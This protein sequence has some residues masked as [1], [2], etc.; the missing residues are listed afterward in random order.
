[1]THCSL[2]GKLPAELDLV[3]SDSTLAAM[4]TDSSVWLPAGG[5]AVVSGEA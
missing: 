4:A 5:H 3:D 1:M 2:K